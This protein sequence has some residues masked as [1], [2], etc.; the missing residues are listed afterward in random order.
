[1]RRVIMDPYRESFLKQM[2]ERPGDHFLRCVFA[3]WLEEQGNEDDS[4]L[5]SALRTLHEGIAA[6]FCGSSRM[7]HSCNGL[8][9]EHGCPYQEEIYGNYEHFCTCCSECMHECD[10][11]I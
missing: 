11:D 2:A 6:G 4:K 5:A 1:M 7:T 10:Q 3:D 8:I 9:E